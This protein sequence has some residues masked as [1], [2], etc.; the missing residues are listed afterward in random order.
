MDALIRYC[1][2]IDPEELDEEQYV[3]LYGQAK[4]V[5]EYVNILNTKKMIQS[6]NGGIA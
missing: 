3:R 5:A 4:W 6:A 2:N 1:F